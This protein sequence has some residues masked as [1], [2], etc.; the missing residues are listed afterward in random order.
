MNTETDFCSNEIWSVYS[1][2]DVYETWAADSPESRKCSRSLLLLQSD[3]YQ[4]LNLFLVDFL[5][6]SCNL[7]IV[8]GEKETIY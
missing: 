2:D 1:S 6:V 8:L 3:V 5:I 4:T 7:L